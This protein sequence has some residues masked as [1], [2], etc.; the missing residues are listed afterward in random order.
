MMENKE[1][2]EFYKERALGP[3]GREEELRLWKLHMS[4]DMK[5][6]DRLVRSYYPF[7]I[8][9]ARKF[10]Y[11]KMP[12]ED[13]IQEGMMGFVHGMDKYDPE[14][15]NRLMTY[16]SFWVRAYIL[17]YISYN[18]TTVRIPPSAQI[19]GAGYSSDLSLNS[20]LNED[21]TE[22]IDLLEDESEPISRIHEREEERQKMHEAIH[23]AIQS[24]QISAKLRPV[25][26][27][28]VERRLLTDEPE[29]LESIGKTYGISRERVRQVESMVKEAIRRS[30]QAIAA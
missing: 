24:R 9:E 15:G 30:Y 25:A 3:I 18:R 4:G 23:R 1:T 19:K 12:L 27:S 2:V 26:Y 14:T 10:L 8:S 22:F 28:V 17:R 7:I 29:I 5:A 21:G 11:R 20:S 13:M 6:R 16:C